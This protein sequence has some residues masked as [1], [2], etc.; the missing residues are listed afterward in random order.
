MAKS[1]RL[2]IAFLLSPLERFDPDG[3][4]SFSIMTECQNRNHPLYAL[5]SRDLLLLDGRLHGRLRRC[6]TDEKAL[7]TEAPILTNLESLDCVFVRKEPPFDLD[8][9][10]CTQLL[11]F[12]KGKVR[13]VN[14]PA[15]IRA[16]GEK[17][18]ALHATKLTPPSF[19]AYD[20][21]N[22]REGMKRLGLEDAVLKRIDQK[23]G[24]GVLRSSPSD[25]RLKDKV[26]ELT[27]DSRVPIVVQKFV[28]HEKTGDKRILILNGKLL[29]AFTRIPGPSDF[30]ANM[31]CG[32]KAARTKLTAKDL[33]IVRELRPFLLK[34]GLF[35][36]GVDVLDGRLSE[37]N[38]T[39]PAGIPEINE[40]E[41]TRL[42]RDVVDFLERITRKSSDRSRS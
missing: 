33:R 37:I 17:I 25:P 27:G 20:E 21:A 12:L 5:E 32:G 42:E 41:G 10:A 22:V 29:G 2:K 40:L 1:K 31:S 35:F 15:G 6:R 3:D 26:R 18:G 9:L 16:V 23:G 30:R 7:R 19:A 39:S 36:A 8:Y 38:V 13:V 4:T 11:D 24:E 28:R 14:D 34:N